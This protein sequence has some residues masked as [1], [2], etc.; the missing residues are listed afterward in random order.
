MSS[1][2]IEDFLVS[3]RNGRT[4]SDNTFK[5]YQI[6]LEQFL[7]FLS[8]TRSTGTFGDIDA[9]LKDVQ[10][11]DI[12]TFFTYKCEEGSVKTANR[13]LAAVRAFFRWMEEEGH[14]ES[15]P[16][17]NLGFKTVSKDPVMEITIDQV[18]DLINSFDPSNVFG[19]RDLVIFFL[20]F[21][22]GLT[23]TQVSD[24]NIRDVDL[25][26]GICTVKPRGKNKLLRDGILLLDEVVLNALRNY[27]N[28][29][30][31]DEGFHFASSSVDSGGCT[32]LFFNKDNGRLS[33]RS[34][35]RR[36]TAHFLELGLSENVGM[37]VFR[38]AY[39]DLVKEK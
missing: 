37:S 34:I 32:P 10:K 30:R 18:E 26:K 23:T 8:I 27:L 13:K 35:R 5:A 17:K 7:V 28:V 39:Q 20:L 29:L 4:R 31:E 9:L 15:S 19:S 3:S 33:T 36:T 38:H 24:M 22:V 11:G 12:Q 1:R 2:Y 14:V 25:D 6:D 16:A 21:R